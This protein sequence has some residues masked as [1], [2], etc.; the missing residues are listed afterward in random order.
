VVVEGSGGEKGVVVRR[1]WWREGEWWWK[2]VVVR[3]EWW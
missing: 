2:G 1:E 3:R